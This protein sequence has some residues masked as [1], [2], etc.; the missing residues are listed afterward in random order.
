ML[1]RENGISPSWRRERLRVENDCSPAILWDL[2]FC[3][4][5]GHCFFAAYLLP[6]D[7]SRVFGENFKRPFF[8]SCV[9]LR[10][11]R[12]LVVLLLLVSV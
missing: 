8:S 7:C 10:G 2:L 9:V 5:S 3:A 1:L 6:W 12:C 11:L 4:F